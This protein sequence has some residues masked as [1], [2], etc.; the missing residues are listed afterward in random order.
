MVRERFSQRLEDLRSEIQ[1]MGVLSQKMLVNSIQALEYLDLELAKNVIEMD[2]IVDDLEYDVEKA[3]VHL[4][5]LQQPMAKDLR[6][7]TASYKI[8]IDLERMSDFAVN[9]AELVSKIEGEHV[10][11]LAE[12]NTIASITQMM[13]ENSM[14]AYAEN[15]AELAKATAEED[16][17]VDRLFYS[18]WQKLVNLMIEDATLI[19]NAVDLIFVLRYLERIAD[20][21]CNICEGVV[22]IATNQRVNLN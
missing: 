19:P 7:I 2:S 13:M 20:H 3:T 9:I 22:Y 15:D 16:S 14:K 21:A 8:A 17:Q 11:P 10:I 6:L 1:E 4:L 5:A 18:T 12:I